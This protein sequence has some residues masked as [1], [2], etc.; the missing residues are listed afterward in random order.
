MFL[1]FPGLNALWQGFDLSSGRIISYSTNGINQPIRFAL[2]RF[3][4]DY[5]GISPNVDFNIVTQGQAVLSSLI[6]IVV[7]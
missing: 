1:I 4:R 5:L 3:L 2:K 6:K 7:Y